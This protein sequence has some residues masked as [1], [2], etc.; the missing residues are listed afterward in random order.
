[1]NAP[2]DV[3]YEIYDA[4]LPRQGPGSNAATRR[5][6]SLLGPVPAAPT[7]LD[8]GCGSG[9][10]TLELA[11]L[12]GG[13]IIALDTYQ[14]YLDRLQQRAASEE[15]TDHIETVNCSMDAMDFAPGSFDVIW[16]EG[17]IYIIGLERGLA[18]CRPLLKP[19]GFLVISDL[20]WFTPEPAPEL[21]QF[22][23]EEQL[24]IR[25]EEENLQRIAQAGYHCL[26]HFR[27]PQEAWWDDFYSLV[28]RK[29][30][31]LE[32]KYRTDPERLAMVDNQ[33][34]EIDLYRAY[35]DQYGYAFYALQVQAS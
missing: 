26:G 33:Q 22:W 31:L 7:M 15:I 6:W 25:T 29:L 17:A 1:M 3:L 10:Q 21:V 12:S 11:R 34:R 8:I 32:Q 13:H 19:G 24:D 28:E 4:D 20:A 2:M 30:S 9:M 35:A 5:A 23:R 27:L 18:V 14:P 16:S